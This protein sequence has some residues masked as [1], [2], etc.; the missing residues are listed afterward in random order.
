MN[1]LVT[2]TRTPQAYAVIRALRPYSDKLV[3]T[4]EGDNRCSA[5]LSHAARS[6]LIDRRY[7][8]PSPAG[9][10]RAGRIQKENTEKEEN[11]IQAMLKICEQEKIDAIFPS[12][13]PHVYVFSKNKERFE[14]R[15]ILIPVPDYDVVITPLDKFRTI[16]A[17]EEVGFPCPK[18]YLVDTADSV[19]QIADE[20][21]FPCV[22]KPRFSADGRGFALVRDLSELHETMRLALKHYEKIMVQE[23]IPGKLKTYYQI[24]LDKQGRLKFAFHGVTLRNFTRDRL[25]TVMETQDAESYG[26]HA[27]SLVQSLRWWGGATLQMKIDSRNK[28]P[29]LMEINPRPGIRLW[30]RT[31]LGINEPLMCLKIARGEAIERMEKYRTR[32]VLVEP[33]EDVLGLVFKVM[34]LLVYKFRI[35]LWGKSPTDPSNPPMNL[36]EI[37]SSYKATYFGGRKKVFNPYFSHF[38]RDPLVSILWWCQFVA[39]A[40]K[41]TKQLGR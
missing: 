36:S 28:V 33:I 30:Q 7:F 26:A 24:V 32:V 37:I 8:T 25:S 39:S 5:W 17:A 14:K 19:G 38:F 2:N 21:S 35:D 31:E 23:Y 3:A 12:F 4:M 10:W 18:T 20:V 13:D 34:D 27:A 15:E 29:K 40:I 9:D 1:L 22:L 16:R 41:A 11:Y 6:R